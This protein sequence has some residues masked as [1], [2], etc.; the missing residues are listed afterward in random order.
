MKLSEVIKLTI[1]KALRE[2][3]GNQ[4]RA[5][6]VLGITRWAMKR[7]MRKYGVVA[8]DYESE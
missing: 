6:R 3:Y 1:A 5:A 4:T 8:A 2:T 7:K